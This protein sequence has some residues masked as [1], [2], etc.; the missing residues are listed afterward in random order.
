MP[1]EAVL[2]LKS[3][4]VATPP[5]AHKRGRETHVGRADSRLYYPSAICTYHKPSLS[6]S[7]LLVDQQKNSF[8]IKTLLFY[9]H[10]FQSI[11][12]LLASQNKLIIKNRLEFKAFKCNTTVVYL[13]HSDNFLF[14]NILKSFFLL[15]FL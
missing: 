7:S 6:R 4:G 1:A 10:R 8:S 13:I 11:L 9:Y 2:G 5:S 14:Y 15:F 12:K 3:H